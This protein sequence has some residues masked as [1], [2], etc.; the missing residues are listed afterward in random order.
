MQVVGA[1][2]KLL[3]VVSM[4][5]ASYTTCNFLT[6]SVVRYYTICATTLNVRFSVVHKVRELKLNNVI[7]IIHF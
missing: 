7:A 1:L 4:K 5:V 3:M 2:S 6:I